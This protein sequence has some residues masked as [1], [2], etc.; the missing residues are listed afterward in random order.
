M[1]TVMK[2]D[3]D[4]LCRP[5]LTVSGIPECQ[6]DLIAKVRAD[7]RE[8]INNLMYSIAEQKTLDNL[9]AKVEA[10]PDADEITVHNGMGYTRK[11]NSGSIW[12]RDVLDLIDGDSNE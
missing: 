5:R 2:A 4:S 1:E 8:H 7:E 11:I 12:R 3:H 10:L 9:R 6:C